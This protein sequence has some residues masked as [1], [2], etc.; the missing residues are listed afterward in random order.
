MG[1]WLKMALV[2]AKLQI[3]IVFLFLL[4]VVLM[5]DVTVISVLVSAILFVCVELPWSN[6]EKWIFSFLLKERKKLN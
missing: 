3:R 5:L 2:V 6:T 4:K 1:W